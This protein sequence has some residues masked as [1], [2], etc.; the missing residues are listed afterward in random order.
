MAFDIVQFLRTN[1]TLTIWAAFFGLVWLANFYGLFGLVFITYILCFLFNGL[2]HTL[3]VKT[4][5]PRTLWAA[6]VYIVFVTVV[7]TIV[8]SVL[9]KLGSES[10]SFLKKLPDTLETLRGHLDNW[11]W[12]APDMAAPIAK[13]K[14]YL[15]LEALVGVKAQTLF[16]IAVNSFN[17][18]STYVSTFL[19]G[20]L[21]SFLIMLDFPNLRAKTISLR[22]SRLRDIY[23]VTARSVVRFAVVVGMGFRAQMLIAAVNT[24]L[25]AIGMH[26]LG[27]EPVMLLSTV[28]FFCGLIP[29]LGTFI[30]SAPIVLV[31]VNTTGPHHALWAIVMIIIVHTIETYILNPRIVAAMFKISPLV[32]LMILYVGHKLFGL[33]GMVLGVP[34]SVFIFRYVILGSDLQKCLPGEK[35]ASCQ[36]GDANAK[37]GH[38]KK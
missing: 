38:G 16:T 22:D 32:T 17:Q 20:T 25:T 28:V 14:D 10:T 15:S 11:A 30:S 34:V 26:F 23:D 3:A 2:I 37:A 1:K 19:L 4:R 24:I 27:I 36:P 35:S 6:V 13:V 33:W 18:I 5:L 12:L 9:P 31:A 29:V 8:S 21:F 7:L